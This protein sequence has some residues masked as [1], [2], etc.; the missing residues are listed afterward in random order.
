MSEKAKAIVA[1]F[2]E[3]VCNNRNLPLADS[4][5]STDH[6]YHD[7]SSPWVGRGPKGMK[8]LVS[9]YQTAF[10]DA[11]WKIEDTIDEGNIVV[12]RWTGT[13]TQ[14]GELMGIA[15]TGNPV[16][17]SGIWIH[18]FA[19][20]KIIESWNVWDTFGMMQQLGVVFQF[21]EAS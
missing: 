8:D 18:E 16:K 4:L 19:G 1:Q 11:H 13:G 3:G 6:V 20:E 21:K 7:P 9:N 14:R 12:T 15:P 17:V 2:F 5:F 10:P